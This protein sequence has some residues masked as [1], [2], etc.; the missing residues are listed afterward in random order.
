MLHYPLLH[1][2]AKLLGFLHE[3][4]RLGLRHDLGRVIV[5]DVALGPSASSTASKVVW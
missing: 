4:F 1:E 3:F 5:E 2:G